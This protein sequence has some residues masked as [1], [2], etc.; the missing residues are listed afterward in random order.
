MNIQQIFSQVENI[1]FFKFMNIQ[2]P[3]Q[4]Y[5]HT[6]SSKSSS[7][8]NNNFKSSQVYE[9]ITSS[10]SCLWTYNKFQV[11]LMDVQQVPSQVHDYTT[12]S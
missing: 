4:V 11:K 8:T 3:S 1:N 12:S 7:W 2:V 6:T 5:G 9:Q 10:K